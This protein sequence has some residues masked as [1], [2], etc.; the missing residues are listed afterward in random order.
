MRDE[1]KGYS[2]DMSDSNFLNLFGLQERVMAMGGE[3]V[4]FSA[5]DHGLI[6]EA[7]IPVQE[8]G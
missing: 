7:N 4:V 6:I 2:I 3:M 1:G 8:E 5:P